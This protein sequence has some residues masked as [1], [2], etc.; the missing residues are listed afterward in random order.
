ME[1]AGEDILDSMET[2][3]SYTLHTM[4]QA[5]KLASSEL[6]WPITQDLSHMWSCFLQK[7]MCEGIAS[8]SLHAAGQKMV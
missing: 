1:E 6:D 3:R 8:V 7:W 4:R 2:A 5:V